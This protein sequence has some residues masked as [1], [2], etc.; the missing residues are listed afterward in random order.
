MRQ[1][2][3]QRKMGRL[4]PV[5]YAVGNGSLAGVVCAF[6]AGRVDVREG[7]LKVVG[8]WI[9]MVDKGMRPPNTHGS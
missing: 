6:L 1:K 5:L 2:K 7:E 9:V 8:E 4:L 3:P